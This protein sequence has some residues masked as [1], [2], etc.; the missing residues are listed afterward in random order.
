MKHFAFLILLVWIS[1]VAPFATDLVGFS[2]VKAAESGIKNGWYSATVKYV[3]YKTYTNAT[4]TLDVHVQYDTVVEID[5]GNGG[6]IHSGYNNSGYTY[7]GGN[8]S[9]ERDFDQNVVAATARVTVYESNGNM[10]TYDI[11]I[12]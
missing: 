3:N 7:T 1:N 6:S 9:I 12:E 2:H 5:F 4:Y 10:K 11:R 8:L